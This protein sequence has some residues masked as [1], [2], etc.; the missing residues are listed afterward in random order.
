MLANQFS[1]S[2]VSKRGE[3][4]CAQVKDP[5]CPTLSR[6]GALPRPQA[7]ESSPQALGSF[8]CLIGRYV[9]LARLISDLNLES[10]VGEVNSYCQADFVQ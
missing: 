10:S 8:C 1:L 4:C 3:G 9:D 6:C 7:A 5:L 2:Q